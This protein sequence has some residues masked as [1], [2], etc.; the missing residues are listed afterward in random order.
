MAHI[1]FLSSYPPTRCGLAT[2]TQHL[3]LAMTTPH[4]TAFV[5]RVVESPTEVQRHQDHRVPVLAHLNHGDLDSVKRAVEQLNAADLAVIQHEYGIYGGTDGNQVLEVMA[6]LT[7]PTIVVL[8]TVLSRPTLGQRQVLE[9]V[10]RL[11][12]AVVE[13][14]DAAQHTLLDQYRVGRS[15][16]TV[17]PHGVDVE[18]ESSDTSH[19]QHDGRESERPV[20]LTWGLLGPGKGIETGITALQYL[21]DLDPLPLYRVLGQT[22]PKVVAHQGEAYRAE[23]MELAISI[24][25]QS[26]VD[27]DGQY[28]GSQELGRALTRADVVLLPYQSRSQV[29]SGCS[30]RRSPPASPS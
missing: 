2:F 14:S 21:S 29:T 28:L 27:I 17:I 9:Q 16:V 5:V 8:H 6:Q 3:A 11:A 10:V 23:L 19:D 13:M 18:A 30:P 26:M 24:G 22:H 1:G 25:V 15:Q 20:I 7:A 4:D 12:S